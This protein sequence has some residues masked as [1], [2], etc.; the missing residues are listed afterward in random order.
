MKKGFTLLELLIAIAIIGILVSIGVASYT[1][2]QKQ[3][4]DA[5]RR[6]DV[7]AVREAW[8]QYYADNSSSY[9]SG[10][11]IAS[12]YLPGGLPEDPKTGDSYE[13]SCSATSYCFCAG[14][15]GSTGNSDE[16]CDYTATTKTHFCVSNVQ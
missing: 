15:E 8:E 2:A 6:G 14:L 3:S 11:S 16:S 4:R 7:R 1:L 5:R 13:V 12:T 9:P 10:C